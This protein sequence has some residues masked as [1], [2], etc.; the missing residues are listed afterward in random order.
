MKKEVLKQCGETKKST[1][2][3]N[4]ENINGIIGQKKFFQVQSTYSN[5]H[6]L[7]MK[8]LRKQLK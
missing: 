3:L 7:N 1:N 8:K 6:N 2:Q 5:N 4:K